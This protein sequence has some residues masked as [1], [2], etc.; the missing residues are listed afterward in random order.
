MV[1]QRP[2]F[3]SMKGILECS[4][5]RPDTNIHYADD[6]T[7][8]DFPRSFEINTYSTKMRNHYLRI[9][10]TSFHL[11]YYGSYSLHELWFIMLRNT[12]ILFGLMYKPCQDIAS[13][14][15]QIT[16]L[17]LC[18]LN[19]KHLFEFFEYIGSFNKQ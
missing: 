2:G 14:Y 5:L 9:F 15:V 7:I 3:A 8:S 17:L 4:C 6:I 19:S 13:S 18:K 11:C 16:Y 10:S 1:V 12:G